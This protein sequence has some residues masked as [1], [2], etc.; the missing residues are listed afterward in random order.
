MYNL[1]KLSNLNKQNIY[2]LKNVLVRYLG[3]IPKTKPNRNPQVE[4]KLFINNDFVNAKSGK[5]FDTFNPANGSL[6]A[7]VSEADSVII[8]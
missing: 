6:I 4:T 5:T 8:R 7:K 1:N 3:A 2:C